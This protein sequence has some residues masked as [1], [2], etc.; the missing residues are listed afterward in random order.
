MKQGSKIIV[1]WT[2][3]EFNRGSD[4][5]FYEVIDT[6]EDGLFVKGI[7]SPEGW[8]HDG[9]KTFIEYD[10]TLNIIEILNPITP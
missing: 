2:T 3:E 4:W 6:C 10:R 8:K 5:S 7:D 1:F 9:S